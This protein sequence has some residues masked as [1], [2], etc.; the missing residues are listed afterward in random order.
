MRP[1][2]HNT[3]QYTTQH[4]TTQ[5]NT[6]QHSTTQHKTTQDNTI[7]SRIKQYEELVA[8]I[9]EANL[10]LDAQMNDARQ[11]IK[12]QSEKIIELEKLVIEQRLVIEQKSKAQPDPIGKQHEERKSATRADTLFRQNLKKIIEEEFHI[13]EFERQ[14]VKII[15]RKTGTQIANAISGVVYGDQMS[16]PPDL[17]SLVF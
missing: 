3:T 17:L 4:N 9:Q 11:Q 2:Q 16:C 12:K 13:N 7:Q 10:S 5:H 8:Q 6:A 1:T 15:S 14:Q